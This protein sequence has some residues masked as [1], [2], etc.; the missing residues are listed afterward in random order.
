MIGTVGYMAPEQVRGLPCDHRA[1]IFAFGC[2]LFEMLSGQRAFKG[3]TA[4][5]T[6]SAILQ[7]RPAAPRR[8]AR[9]RV[10]GLQHTVDRCLEK[11]PE[12]R[13]SSAH[14]LALALEAVSTGPAKA[15]RGGK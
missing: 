4:A 7:G 3:A 12:D 8:P 14:D 9:G 10:P 15:R 5:D 1:D 2:V 11:Q 6:M 13:F